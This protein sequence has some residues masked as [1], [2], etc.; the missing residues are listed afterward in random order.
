M[1]KIIY[2]ISFL[3]MLLLF[4]VTYR[5]KN[6]LSKQLSSK[7]HPLKFLYGTAFFLYDIFQRLHSKFRPNEPIQNAKLREKL[8]QLHV[9]QDVNIIE[10]IFYGKR[11]SYAYVTL[12][13]FC[14]IGF[15]YCVSGSTKEPV[16]SVERTDEDETKNLVM[17]NSEGET[18]NVQLNIPAQQYDFQQAFELFESYREELIQTMLGDNTD[19]ETI[20]KPLNFITALDDSP[21]KISWEIENENLIDYTGKIHPENIPEHGSATSVTATLTID[22][23][24]SKLTIPL[25]LVP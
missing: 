18:Q 13:L 3:I 5:Y 8:K 19:I 15:A 12:F 17:E 4:M 20:S 16:T 23:H 2:L 11:I 14:F 1:V 24:T 7:Q 10:Y 6:Q 22:T 25:V 9:G 21:L